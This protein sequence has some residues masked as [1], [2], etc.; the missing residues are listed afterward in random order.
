MKLSY[1]NKVILVVVL[2]LLTIVAGYIWIITPKINER[3][4][5]VDERAAVQAEEQALKDK[6]ASLPTLIERLKEIAL[7]VEET[8]SAFYIEDENFK[9][10]QYIYNIIKD[11]GVEITSLTVS[12]KSVYPITEYI[13][14]YY[15][16]IGYDLKI[17][18][19]LYGELS[20]EEYNAYNNIS[21][22]APE[23]KNIGLTTVT[24]NFISGSS[25]KEGRTQLL[26]AIENDEK[27]VI[28]T[29]LSAG[30]GGGDVDEET[31]EVSTSCTI[32]IFTIKP[33]NI[34]EVLKEGEEQTEESPASEEAETDAEAPEQDE[35]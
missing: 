4:A 35:S 6:I 20:E 31:N 32:N 9:A 10:D 23:P 2:A 27:T 34:E 1:R 18:G 26:N 29:S 5:A 24:I 16:V 3:K 15:N 8:Q 7:S 21:P 33:M 14:P 22:A 17:N 28:L 19:D 11:T 12:D 30:E 13:L 25:F